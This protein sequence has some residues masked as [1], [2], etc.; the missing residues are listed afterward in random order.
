MHSPHVRNFV[1][2][3]QGIGDDGHGGQLPASRVTRKRQQLD[4]IMAFVVPFLLEYGSHST[5]S[6]RRKVVVDFCCG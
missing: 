5:S 6:T 4:N 2:N 1:F 3:S